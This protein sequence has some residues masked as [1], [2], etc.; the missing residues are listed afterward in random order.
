MA[1]EA[2]EAEVKEVFNWI[3]ASPENRKSFINY[4]QLWSISNYSQDDFNRAWDELKS[5]KRFSRKGKRVILSVLKYAAIAVLL[6]CFGSL[7]QYFLSPNLKTDPIYLEQTQFEVP[8]GQMSKITLPDG[9]LI[10]LNSGSKLSYKNNFSSG[11]RNVD[12]TGEAFFDVKTD[13]EHPFTVNTTGAINMKVYGTSFN[14]RAYPE[15]REINA[16]LVEGSIGILD[17]S[18]N[19]LTRLAPGENAKY[20]DDFKR[21]VVAQ[22]DT[23][24]YTSWKDGL[25]TFRNE[26]LEQISLKIERWYNVEIVIENP[27]LANELYNGTIMK[28][29]PID[30]ILEVFRL[31]SPLKYKIVSRPDKP[32]L[33]YWK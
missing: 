10:H 5:D 12:L 1:G 7:A 8:F 13:K 18:G 21:I 9:T 32:T 14:V 17:N 25:V 2:S 29:K 16:T 4:K 33:I 30:Q 24:F 26:S 3:E 23:E 22:V 15:D 27:E 28:N 6:L 11:N 31:T 19:E 20:S